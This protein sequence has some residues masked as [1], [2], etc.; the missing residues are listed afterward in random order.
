V[1]ASPDALGPDVQ[2]RSARLQF[3]RAL[4][5]IGMTLLAPGSAQVAA[6]NKRI[7]HIALR[8]WLGAVAV[9][10]A[11]IVVYL[12]WRATAFTLLTNTGVLGGLRLVLI[13]AA[14]AWAALLIDAWRLGNPPAMGQRQR[15]AVVSIDGVAC[16]VVTGALLFAS[17]LVAVQKD[18]IEFMFG[19]GHAVGAFDGRY[20][21]LLLG[22]DSGKTR[23]GLRPDSITLASIDEDSGRT[24]LFGLPRN[25]E[26]VPFPDGSVMHQRFPHGFTASP[27]YLNAVNTWA[28]EHPG[29]FPASVDDPGIEATKEAVEGVTGLRINYYAM[30]N[31]YGFRSLVDA[32][33]GLTLHVP[34]RV[35]VGRLG[36]IR[37]WI[38]PG[39]QHL[40]GFH[41]LWFA[42]SRATSDDY[43]RM[44][45]Q[46]CVMSA[47]LK[48]L[49]PQTA[50]THFEAIAA[51]GKQ[52][53]STDMPASEL[54]RFA[55]LALKAKSLPIATVSFVPPLIKTYDPDFGEIRTL[56][57][58]A[59]E[60][61]DAADSGDKPANHGQ[62]RS[63]NRSANVTDNL[64]ASC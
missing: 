24:I 51:A 25:L 20:N 12:G 58:Q 37:D 18:F 8:V 46:K 41:T 7:G 19:D 21:V 28:T 40:D 35:P 17:H 45:R 57:E 22:A 44:A 49:S 33:G 47:M 14:F 42:R 56:V 61:A 23:V 27:D 64:A 43:S 36:D 10:L 4:T 34:E 50:I 5:L 13:V 54:G 11:L 60:R 48:Q 52:L 26:H 6:G 3:R 31:L 15:L 59:V 1:P 32:M 38:E 39:T 63:A 30:I 55:D 53:M 2:V 29:L 16:V 9:L 62:R